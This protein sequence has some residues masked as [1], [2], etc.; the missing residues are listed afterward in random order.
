[1]ARVDMEFDSS[2]YSTLDDNSPLLVL[3]T[4]KQA[5]ILSSIAP[6]L[7][8]RRFWVATDAEWDSLQNTIA[9]AIDE[10]NDPV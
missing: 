8:Y 4:Q 9:N 5:A 10:V 3:L 1:M 7:L 6:L 2:D